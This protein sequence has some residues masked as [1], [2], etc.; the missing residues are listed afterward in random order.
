MRGLEPPRASGCFGKWHLTPEGEQGPA[1]PFNRWPNALGLRLLL[2]L[3]RRRGRPV[4]HHDRRERQVRSA[5]PGR[6]E[7][8]YFPDAMTDKTIEWLHGVRA[9]R[10]RQAVVRV[11]LDRLQPRPAPRRRRSGRTGT[12]ASST[13]AGTSCARRRFAR[14]KELGVDPG[15]RGAHAAPR[16]DARL[17]L[18]PREPASACSP[19]RWR[20]TPAS[21]RTP[22][23]TSAGVLDAIAEMGELD[24]TL[25]VYIWGDNGA[26]LEGTPDRHVQRAGDDERASRSPTSS[27]CSSSLKWGGLEAWGTEMMYPHYSSAWAWAGNC[28]FQWGKQVAS[29][30]GGTRNPLV[31]R[32]PERIADAG[33]LR[34]QFTHVSD[35][36][37]T[38]LERVGVPA[39]DARRRGR[40]AAD[41][42][43]RA[44]ATRS[45]TPTRPSSTPSSTS[46]T[47]ATARCT[48]TAGGCR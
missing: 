23:T 10:L 38:I 45:T 33:G 44:S 9:P 40:A 19:A 34:S 13:R 39:A 37:P 4:R 28:P 11:L 43:A 25:V 8:F 1:G 2:G 14:Q 29:H 46:R 47:S 20:S 5:S 32:W 3:P 26:S 17:G 22:T 42:R 31:V 30:L 24:N 15:R 7:D 36:G 16:G 12:R 6:T 18:A 21:A 41:A 48:R 35:I 27:R